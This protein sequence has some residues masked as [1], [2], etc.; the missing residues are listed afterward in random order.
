MTSKRT[1]ALLTVLAAVAL[2]IVSF[3]PAVTGVSSDPLLGGS[4]LTATGGDAIPG[5]VTLA[6]ALVAAALA[7]MTSGRIARRV[8]LI[9][10]AVVAGLLLTLTVRVLADP[11]GVLGPLAAGRVGRSGTVDV[12]ATAT[13]WVWLALAAG[14]LAAVA[15][16]L[17]WL[18]ATSWGG[19]GARYDREPSPASG[20]RGERVD[21][22]WDELSAGRDPTSGADLP[23]WDPNRPIDPKGQ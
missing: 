6:A 15:L 8:S 10:Y 12:S 23:Q 17:G 14:L 13:G 4:H 3:R 9:A 11:A 19:L 20:E 16:V 21:R 22:A 7:A 5:L 1:V 18:G 2:V